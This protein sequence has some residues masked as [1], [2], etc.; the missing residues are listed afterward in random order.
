M[1]E[2]VAVQVEVQVGVSV[3]SS[4]GEGVGEN[5]AI[6]VSR[7]DSCPLAGAN[8]AAGR[9]TIACWQPVRTKQATSNATQQM[10]FDLHTVILRRVFCAEESPSG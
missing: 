2:G 7:G 9:G 5:V 10:A 1:G 8:I 3:G 4:V 6:V